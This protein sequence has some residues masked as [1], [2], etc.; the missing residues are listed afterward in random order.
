MLA[1]GALLSP[2]W[3]LFFG[4]LGILQ[5]VSKPG[6]SRGGENQGETFRRTICGGLG[7]VCSARRQQMQRSY[8]AGTGLDF[9]SEHRLRH[10]PDFQERRTVCH[11]EGI[12]KT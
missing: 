7:G 4:V 8:S 9:C 12:E 1:L 11:R 3:Q 10:W 5:D 2:Q 6:N